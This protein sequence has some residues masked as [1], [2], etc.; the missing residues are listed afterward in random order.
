MNKSQRG[1]TLLESLIGLLIIAAIAFGG[2]YIRHRNH[3][4]KPETP[5]VNTTTAKYKVEN[6]GALQVKFSKLP[7]GLKSAI[8]TQQEK[9]SP[10]C[11]KNGQ[12]VDV[13][14]NPSDPTVSYSSSRAAIATIGCD[15]GAAGLFAIDKDGQWQF[16]ASTQSEF[17]CTDLVDHLVPI[18]LLQIDKGSSEQPACL[19]SG[20]SVSYDSLFGNEN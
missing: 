3:A 15:G 19:S 20:K 14:G 6:T 5:V 13:N 16:I 2:F 11:V 10:A 9:S 17:N 8:I 7:S 12:L 18:K 4:T 1:F